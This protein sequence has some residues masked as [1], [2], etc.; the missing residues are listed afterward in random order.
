MATLTGAPLRRID[1]DRGKVRMESWP[2]TI[3]ACIYSTSLKPR[4]HSRR[5]LA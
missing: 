4:C 2:F 1:V 3:P 5:A